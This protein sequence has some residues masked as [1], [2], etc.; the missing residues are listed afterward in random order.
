VRRRDHAIR[1]RVRAVV[2]RGH[3][4]PFDGARSAS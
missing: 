4:D 1:C 2:V 3:A